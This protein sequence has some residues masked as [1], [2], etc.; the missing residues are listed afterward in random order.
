MKQSSRIAVA[1]TLAIALV[2]SGCAFFDVQD[3][4]TGRTMPPGEWLALQRE[5]A[6]VQRGEQQ[7][8]ARL[9]IPETVPGRSTAEWPEAEGC[10]VMDDLAV[11]ADVDTVYARAMRRYAFATNEQMQR[12]QA[13]RRDVIIHP[14]FKHD[15]QAGAFYR[16]A[17]S[18]EFTDSS[19]HKRRPWVELTLAKDGPARTIASPKYCL[20]QDGIGSKA[21]ELHLAFQRSLAQTLGQ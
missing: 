12:L 9:S 13:E 18:V 5:R 11:P 14:R 21:A 15:R 3:K 6:K 8:S 19:G 7:P 17:Q 4:E 10:R 16:M 2:T 1:G 20:H